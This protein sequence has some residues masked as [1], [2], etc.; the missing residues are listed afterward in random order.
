MTT[1][2]KIRNSKQQWQVYLYVKVAAYEQ[3]K[4]RM[5][6]RKYWKYKVHFIE[7]IGQTVSKGITNSKIKQQQKRCMRFLGSILFIYICINRQKN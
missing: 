2:T 3:A 5:K 4:I 1:T 7:F 6:H